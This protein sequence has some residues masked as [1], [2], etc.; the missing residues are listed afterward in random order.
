MTT[1]DTRVPAGACPQRGVAL[2]AVLWIVAALGIIVAG[3]VQAQRDEIHTVATSRQLVEGVALGNAGIQLV[4]QQLSARTEPLTQLRL[5]EVTF[6]SRVLTVEVTPLNG[7][8]DLNRAPEG[9]IAAMFRVPGGLDGPRAAGLAQAV[10]SA[11]TAEA[12]ARGPR[13]E[14]PEDLLQVPGI[15][16]DLYARLAPLLT[17]DA[18]GTGMVNAL[19]APYEVLLVLTQGDSV[20]AA[21]I[22]A[23][24]RS[25]QPGTDTT[26]LSGPFIDNS[27]SSRWRLQTWVRMADGKVVRVTRSAQL[28]PGPANPSPWRI[29]QAEDRFEPPAQKVN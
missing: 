10:A 20:Q 15:D 26:G 29:L 5:F 13:F 1:R 23:E 21:K 25:G 12:G 6:D 9:L 3:L 22:D 7:L 27:V 11:R 18:T 19:A 24:R 17:T 16:Y 4:M 14:A 2:I 28:T 8:I